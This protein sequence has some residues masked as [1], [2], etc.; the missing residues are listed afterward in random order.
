MKSHLMMAALFAII[1][2]PLQADWQDEVTSRQPDPSFLTIRPVHLSFQINWNGKIN[3]GHM[4]MLFGREDDRY[5]SHFITQIYGASTGLARS[6]YPY[7]Y[8]FT[9]F[10][11]YGSYLP[12]MFTSSET[13]SKG[14]TD[15]SNWY[16]PTVRSR[17]TF[18]PFRGGSGSKKKNSTFSFRKA[19][20]Y[21]F[22]SALIYLRRLEM[23]TGEKAVIVVHPFSSPYLARVSVLRREPHR[24]LKCIKMDIKLQK[25]GA[26]GKLIKYDKM[27][28]ATLWLSDDHE[29]LPVELRTEVFI[30]DVRAILTGKKYL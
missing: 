6:L 1:T 27:K 3:S 7:D 23:K 9:S 8:S 30:G 20:I 17:E 4:N 26:G 2:A 10:L 15:T 13:T 12:S 16:G 18:I 29:R 5:P 24:G 28:T 22:A 21:D 11:K 25:I 19:P 14:R